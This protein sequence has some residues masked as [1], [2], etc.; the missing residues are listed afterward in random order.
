MKGLAPEQKAAFE[1]KCAVK[2]PCQNSATM[3][4]QG[5]SSADN[6]AKVNLA[7]VRSKAISKEGAPNMPV[8]N[9]HV[10]EAASGILEERKTAEEGRSRRHKL[11]ELEEKALRNKEMISQVLASMNRQIEK[12]ID[13]AA[14]T[15]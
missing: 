5:P 10:A 8:V 14:G 3:L 11:A 12:L 6:S 2:W 9:L 7:A 4:Q 1:M 15:V 13:L